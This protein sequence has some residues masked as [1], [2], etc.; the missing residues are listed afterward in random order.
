MGTK[1]SI[2]LDLNAKF[3][4]TNHQWRGF[5]HV[6]KFKKLKRSLPINKESIKRLINVHFQHLKKI[7]RVDFKFLCQS[8]L[9]LNIIFNGKLLEQFFLAI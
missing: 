9:K 7:Y 4:T 3:S 6:S 8:V 2:S 1:N 5:E